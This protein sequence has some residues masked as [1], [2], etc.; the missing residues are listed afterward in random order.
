MRISSALMIGDAQIP[1]VSVK[2]NC[3]I[4]V[5]R[6]RKTWRRPTQGSSFVV[7]FLGGRCQ[8]ATLSA[9]AESFIGKTIPSS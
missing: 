8:Q 6:V 7:Y 2:K 5:V 1:L 4:R 3:F 9:S